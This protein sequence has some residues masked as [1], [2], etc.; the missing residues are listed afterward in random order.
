MSHYRQH[1][2]S[3]ML[4]WA[5]LNAPPGVWSQATFPDWPERPLEKK[6]QRYQKL[7]ANLSA[8]TLN[9]RCYDVQSYALEMRIEPDARWIYARTTVQF[10]VVTETIS[11]LELNFGSHLQVDSVKLAGQK[12]KFQHLADLLDV[13]L[14]TPLA[15]P[16]TAAVT[17]WYQ[18]N[19]SATWHGTFNF[20]QFASLP[21]I[22]TLSEPFGARDWWPCKDTP[23]DKADSVDLRITVPAPLIVASN[24]SL[25]STRTAGKWITYHWHEAYPI[26]TYLVSLAIYP[27]FTYTDSYQY[28]ASNSMPVQFYVF[29]SHY[30][31]L[32][33]NYAQT[34]PALAIFSR[35][36]GPYPFLK[37]KYGHAEFN[38]SGGMEHQ[39]LTSLGSWSLSL[40]V[41]E[42]A[43]QWWGD[44][45]TCRDFH[46]IWLNEGFATYSEALFYEA[47]SG[48][49][50]YFEVL[51]ALQYFG[52][53]SIYVPDLTDV[54]RI[55]SGDLSYHKAAWV[56]HSLRRVV[57]DTTF[58]KI[59]RAWYQHPDHQYGTAI[60]EDFQHVCEAVSGQALGWFF[61]EWIYGEYYPVY[62]YRWEAAAVPGG[63][64]IDL[65]L[66]QHP[67]NGWLFNMPI[68][69]NFRGAHQ[70]TT[71]VFW[72]SL[73]VQEFAVTLPFEPQ[74]VTLD[75]ENW[76]LKEVHFQ[77]P[78]PDTYLLQNYP[79]PFRLSSG[80]ARTA[81]A[82]TTIHYQINQS[83]PV[84]LTIYNALGQLVQTLVDQFQLP[85]QYRVDW[86]GRAEN[87]HRVP[88]GIYFY[89]LQLQSHSESKKF[90]VL[91]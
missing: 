13:Q 20:D 44:M 87:G 72:D 76:I 82:A 52:A 53:G 84:R 43:H 58:F 21:M 64:Q 49:A 32:R 39:T 61:A 12:L 24:G 41:H 56:L 26:A 90:L 22:W 15:P 40:I 55:F 34:V 27:Y 46:H 18:G 4:V 59:L 57:G 50:A 63:F 86:E 37:E 78:R 16:G 35:L 31:S 79:N 23:A 38:W 17:V 19:P 42:L 81:T 14:P 54:A 33:E 77:L 1:W 36:F 60:T 80:D 83:T 65:Q 51:K 69:M 89:R 74:Q 71:R 29:P 8:L 62:S 66:R 70:E 5:S 73:E 9:Q 68:D 75:P 7:H 11:H 28:D 88:A 10:Q 91:P 48:K 67:I 2:C 3:L 85:H 6:I 30:P 25:V 45:I 47:S